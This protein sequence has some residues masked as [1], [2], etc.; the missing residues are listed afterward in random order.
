MASRCRRRQKGH[1][2]EYASFILDSE[3]QVPRIHTGK[4]N[5]TELSR[6]ASCK[7]DGVWTRRWIFDERGSRLVVP[8]KAKD[9]PAGR[10]KFSHPDAATVLTRLSYYSKG[11]SDQEIRASFEAVLQTD[12]A[13][14]CLPSFNY[15]GDTIADR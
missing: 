3:T 10:A 13:Q 12:D 4:T 6:D 7:S 5:I 15:A 2:L 11:R 9:I 8:Y 1:I 14:D